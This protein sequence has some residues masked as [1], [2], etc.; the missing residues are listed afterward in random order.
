MNYCIVRTETQRDVFD[1]HKKFYLIHHLKYGA[2][3]YN[4]AQSK[5]G[6]KLVLS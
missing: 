6:S 5:R 3:P 2:L 4:Q 1:L